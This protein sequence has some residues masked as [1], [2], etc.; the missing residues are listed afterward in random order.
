MNYEAVLEPA[1]E[2][3]DSLRDVLK[4][5]ASE[6]FRNGIYGAWIGLVDGYYGGENPEEQA[7]LS[8]F[9]RSEYPLIAVTAN[10]TDLRYPGVRPYFLVKIDPHTRQRISYGPYGTEPI[11]VGFLDANGNVIK[12][13]DPSS[14]P[15]TY[16][17]EQVL[18]VAQQ[19]QELETFG[20]TIESVRAP[21][22]II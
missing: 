3:R 20:I 4:R 22:W 18:L 10:Y 12:K 13:E 1:P 7:K 6:H 11:I 17:D 2:R 8:A 9:A 15:S 21:G 14:N 19:A 16:T 5:H